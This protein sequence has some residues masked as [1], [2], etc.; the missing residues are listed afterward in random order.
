MT[1]PMASIETPVTSSLQATPVDDL[2]PGDSPF[3]FGVLLSRALTPS[4]PE[5]QLLGALLEAPGFAAE[6][7]FDFSSA[8]RLVSPS[9][10]THLAF[11]GEGDDQWSDVLDATPSVSHG[12]LDYPLPDPFA[13]GGQALDGLFASAPDTHWIL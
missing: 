4:T 1:Q 5:D 2:L 7:A 12:S 3:D 10:S 11:A 13:Y 9:M 6:E 8:L